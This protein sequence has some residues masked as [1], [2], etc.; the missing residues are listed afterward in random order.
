MVIS[1]STLTKALE[2]ASNR[3]CPIAVT[4]TITQKKILVTASCFSVKLVNLAVQGH[5]IL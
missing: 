5:Q 4:E 1:I 3:F 2:S